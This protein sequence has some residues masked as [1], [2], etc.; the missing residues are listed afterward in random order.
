MAG[1][2]S[3]IFKTDMFDEGGSKDISGSGQSDGVSGQ[4]D[5]VICTGGMYG[6]AGGQDDMP[7]KIFGPEAE[8][9]YDA[10]NFIRIF[11]DGFADIIFFIG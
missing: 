6:I 8:I 10:W 3:S 1:M 11:C 4:S 5:A 7:W 9:K 2:C